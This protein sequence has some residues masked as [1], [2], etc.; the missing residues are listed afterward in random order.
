MRKG[1]RH[2]G[3]EPSND[4]TSGKGLTYGDE[5][6]GTSSHRMTDDE[7][8]QDFLRPLMITHALLQAEGWMTR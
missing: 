4:I 8:R 2:E 5:L 3:V 1:E 6:S 7:T